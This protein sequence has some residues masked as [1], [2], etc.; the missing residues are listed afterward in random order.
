MS[1]FSEW[2]DKNE[3]LQHPLAWCHVTHAHTWMQILN[4]G[5]CLTKH[6]NV[7]GEHLLYFFYGRPAFR[8]KD[9][10]R[11]KAGSSPVVLLFENDIVEKGRSIF[12]F[13]TGAFMHGKFKKQVLSTMELRSFEMTCNRESPR[14]HV[15]ALYG[16]NSN[17]FET[18]PKNKKDIR[19]FSGYYEVETVINIISRPP[20]GDTDD[21]VMAVELQVGDPIETTS[22][23][24]KAVIYPSELAQSDEMS[25]FIANNTDNIRFMKY[26][27]SPNKLASEYQSELEKKARAV[28]KNLGYK[29]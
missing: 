2:L 28:Q 6:C 16:S 22:G 12:P 3:P 24:L 8:V 20:S 18:T 10:E 15:A 11:G 9:E 25:D 4:S 29:T 27:N 5:R 1:R 17:Y 19:N 13:D 23:Q 21:R 26:K 14:R 7:F